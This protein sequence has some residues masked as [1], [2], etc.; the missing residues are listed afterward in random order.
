[1]SSRSYELNSLTGEF[2]FFGNARLENFWISAKYCGAE[3]FRGKANEN[4]LE[5]LPLTYT[6]YVYVGLVFLKLQKI[7]FEICTNFFRAVLAKNYISTYRENYIYI[8][9]SNACATDK[10][11][12]FFYFFLFT[13]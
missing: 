10:F 12:D 5:N 3:I 2:F 7:F 1:M 8:I 4:F 11:A 9:Y 6:Y 13:A